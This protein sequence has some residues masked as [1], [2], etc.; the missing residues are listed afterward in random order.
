MFIGIDLGT[1]NS[2][3]VGSDG[4]SLRL[5][6]TA[7]GMDVMPS[8][9]MVDR[10]GGLFVGRKAYD[11]SA[12]SPQSVQTKFKRLMGTGSTI[13][14]GSTDKSLS[15]EEASA[16][17]I[18][19]LMAQASRDLPDMSVDGA[20]ITIPAAFNQMQSE[21]TMRAAKH[22][23]LDNVAL[24]QEP[25]AAAMAAMTDAK[26]GSGQFLIYD[27][28]GG[29]FDA[30]IVQSIAG[31]ITVV[32]HAGVNM[33][34]GADF[35]RAI[36]NSIVRPWL[37]HNFSLP[38]DFQTKPEYARLIRIAHYRAEICKIA[39]SSQNSDHVFADENQLGIKDEQGDE[40]YLDV[41][42]S[43]S[44]L[45]ELI[46]ENVDRSIE[47]CRSLLSNN[48]YSPTDMDRV[49]MIGGPSRMPYVRERV[50]FELGIAVDT[51]VD[52]MTAVATGAAV[53]ASGRDWEIAGGAEANTGRETKTTNS[54]LQLSF[55][56]IDNTASS[57]VRLRIRTPLS[58]VPDNTTIQVEA[59]N[60]WTS[61]K[62]PLE[63]QVDVKSVPL[64]RIGPNQVKVMVFDATGAVNSEA[65]AD[66]TITRLQATSD[67]MPL[68]HN[69]AIKVVKGGVG[70]ERNALKTLIEKG[71]STP[72][73][74]MESFRAS[75]DLRA[76]EKSALVFEL[77]EQAD[78]VNSPDLNLA[79]GSFELKG[80]SL[81]PGQMIR[82]GDRVDVHWSIDANSLLHCSFEL[83]DIGLFHSLENM[84]AP[85]TSAANFDGDE[86]AQL[87]QQSLA[88]ARDDLELLERALGSRITNESQDIRTKLDKHQKT[89][90]MAYDADTRRMITQEAR[91][92][93]QE[94]YRLRNAT[95]NRATIIQI[96]IDD[97]MGHYSTH[98]ANNVDQE[99][100]TNVTRQASFARD[101][102]RQGDI[103]EASQA[104][105]EARALIHT[106]IM[107]MP[108]F[109]ASQFDH[110]IK[111]RYNAAD[112]NRHDA[113][114]QR[115]QNAIR[116][117]DLDEL[118]D[119]VIDMNWNMVQTTGG[120]N[121]SVLS[122]LME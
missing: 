56:Y 50:G 68:M 34:G 13:E 32:A 107:Q 88:D 90:S 44:H 17:V 26:E 120:A 23:G 102:L 7:E 69:L 84:Y 39:L 60:G 42:V 38:E 24:L 86:G 109:W 12:F 75:R 16:E 89:L 54:D 121:S 51:K 18:K 70:A 41:E 5:F 63:E 53:Y 79:I 65:S 4:E 92:L 45:E 14:F 29:T 99:T 15:P 71:A 9:I 112:K 55:D 118:K 76:G 36:V 106:H 114:V 37:I 105:E 98:I 85:T 73:R 83:P 97:L 103:E 28:G 119:V 40:I 61:G 8:A 58:P 74:G 59:A 101:A 77:F 95:E 108:E 100:H 91:Y 48:G 6:K 22:A 81:T 52:P 31:N 33:L 1:T 80:D 47:V 35:D 25:I 66:L 10:R 104:L 57:E 27:L 46:A 3:V 115:G 117:N 93:R 67:G 72:A 64:P 43:R 19:A 2:A 87:A 122:G 94:I 20:V 11:Q 110:F 96:E 30:A 78:G 21:A 111:E 49:V 82:K 62:L 116:N 113:L